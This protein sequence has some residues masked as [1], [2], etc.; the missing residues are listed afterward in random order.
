MYLCRVKSKNAAALPNIGFQA[1]LCLYEIL[2]WKIDKDN[3]QYK[4][5]RLKIA[6]RKVKK[7]MWFLIPI[8]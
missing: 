3:M 4:L 2:G 7:G 6:A 1:Q 5:F 8:K